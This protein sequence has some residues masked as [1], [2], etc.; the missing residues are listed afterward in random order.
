[1]RRFRGFKF[2][3]FWTRLQGYQE[4]VQQAWARDVHVFNPLLRLH[5]K[6]QRTSKALRVWARRLIGNNKL[7]LCAARQLIG[8]LDVVQ[9]FRPLSDHE[10]KLKR[11]LKVRFLG[12]TAVEKLRAKQA[13]RLVYIQAAE[14]NS[15]L[16]FLQ[17]N[18][19]RRKNHIHMLESEAGVC[20]SHEQKENLLHQ[21]YSEHFG[22]PTQRE[23]TLNWEELGLFRHDLA[24]LEDLFSE[25]EVQGVVSDIAADKA[26]GPD[27][28]IGAFL[29]KSWHVIK[30][31][32]MQAL[33]FFYEQHDQHF[34]HLNSAHILLI[35]KKADAKRVEDYSPISLS[36]CFGK[37]VSKLLAGRLAPELDGLVS[38][39]QSAFIKRRSIQDNFLYTQNLVRALHRGKKAGLFL[40]LDIAKA[41]DSVRWDY[42]MEVLQQLGSGAKW[43]SWV[44]ILLSS[45]TSTV[46]LNGARGEWFK[47]HTGLRQGDPLSPMLFILAMEPLSRMIEMAVR[48]H[49]ISPLPV[50]GAK[51]RISLF[52]DDAALFLNPVKEEVQMVADILHVFGEVSG[53]LTNQAKCA[54]YPIMCDHINIQE[55]M[56]TFQCPVQS[57]PYTYLGLPLHTRQLR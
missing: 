46:L 17:A 1:M 34:S 20:L 40:K 5:I 10:L 29:K 39:A 50:R 9:D 16:F 21:H 2:E 45:C 22:R 8:I 41:F 13:S 37:L 28:F 15:K 12:L 23:C 6:L 32:L 57:F 51:L 11:D 47:H 35:P 56:A 26:P 14:A 53:L 42:L 19:R 4:V 36:H 49:L 55:V 33:N 30:G 38:R 24:H 18:G 44:S 48:D 31:D 27:G 25:E 52:A 43:R 54:V 7:L 3:A